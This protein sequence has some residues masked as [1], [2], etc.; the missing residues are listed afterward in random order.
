MRPLEPKGFKG[1]LITILV[2]ICVAVFGFASCD[3]STATTSPSASSQGEEAS[4]TV[5]STVFASYDYARQIAGSHAQVRML[6]PPG[7]EVHSFEPTPQDIM[8][9]QKCD[10]FIY[11]G[12]DSDAW[13]ASLLSSIDTSHTTIIKLMD[14][15]PLSDEDNSVL[16]NPTTGV[17]EDPESDEHVWTSIA[18][19]KLMC[20]AI[21]HTLK[22]IDPSNATDYEQNT[23]DYL[24][25]LDQLD[26]QYKQ[27]ISTAKRNILVFGDRF[28]F[29]YLAQEYGLKCYAAFPGCSTATEPSAQTVAALIDI[30]RK[31]KIPVVFYIEL[32]NHSMA[33]VIAQETGAK[34]LL[35]HSCH[36]VTRQDF[37]QGVTYLSIMEQ[38]LQNLKVALN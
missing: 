21:D 38:N 11:V 5:I 13:V 14:C 35:L 25:Q 2:V 1:F 28:P 17:Q 24:R 3:R 8:D 7:A 34:A 32:S 18:N 12:G 36:N 22:T 37:Q 26:A 27:V 29:H 10:L 20:Q 19:A 9:I 4:L 6:V 30:I 15:V 31:D 33:D 16:V 23:Q